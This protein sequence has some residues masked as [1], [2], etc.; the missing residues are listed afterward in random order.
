MRLRL[1]N[2]VLFWNFVQS[3]VFLVF[4]RSLN[5]VFS[6]ASDSIGRQQELQQFVRHHVA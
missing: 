6:K 3:V 5:S 4:N 2:F 1:W